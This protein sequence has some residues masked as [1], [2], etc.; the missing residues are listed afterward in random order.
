[1]TGDGVQLCIPPL[2]FPES[3]TSL[4]EAVGR[5]FLL[6]LAEHFPGAILVSLCGKGQKLIDSLALQVGTIL[7]LIE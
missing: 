7:G 4:T 5:V 3:T 2:H 6:K 1:M